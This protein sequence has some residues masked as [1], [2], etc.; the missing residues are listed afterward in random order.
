MPLPQEWPRAERQQPWVP[1]RSSGGATP[2]NFWLS[3]PLS[4]LASAAKQQRL[5]A[6]AERAATD[7][8]AAL[9]LRSQVD[10]GEMRQGVSEIATW[11]GMQLASA[12]T[13]AVIEPDGLEKKY[14]LFETRRPRTVAHLDLST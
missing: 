12:M 2:S 5:V 8:K 4:T 13:E 10:D 9:V 3:A 1:H 7:T 11:Y 6:A 14:H